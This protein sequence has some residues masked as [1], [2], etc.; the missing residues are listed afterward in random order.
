MPIQNKSLGIMAWLL[1]IASCELFVLIAMLPT[2]MLQSTGESEYRMTRAF[3]GEEA[4]DNLKSKADRFYD[5]VFNKTGIVEESFSAFLPTK[6][7]QAGS[8][9]LEKLG[10]GM[11]NYINS[12]L[13]TF[14]TAIYLGVYRI[15]NLLTWAPGF[16]PIFCAAIYDGLVTRRIR[17][18]TFATSSAI[19]YGSSRT[20]VFALLL[21]PLLY[22]IFPMPIPPIIAPM[23]CGVFALSC[24]AMA[25]NWPRT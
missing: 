6:A 22:A 15:F 13:I 23:W 7:S 16:I 9:G 11:F 14:W 4:A 3:L 24:A 8:R 21:G 18:L 10:S 2:S 1:I 19:V 25:A 12:R 5:D 17:Y 20:M